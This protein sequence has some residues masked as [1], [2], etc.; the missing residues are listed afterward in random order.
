[1]A[2]HF[3]FWLRHAALH[4]LL[5]IVFFFCGNCKW[6]LVL[7][8]NCELTFLFLRLLVVCS[9]KVFYIYSRDHLRVRFSS[10]FI[11]LIDFYF[12][13]KYPQRGVCIRRLI[14]LKK[15]NFNHQKLETTMPKQFSEIFL[16]QNIFVIPF[17]LVNNINEFI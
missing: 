5:K 12:F 4:N 2:C 14:L 13:T 1:M 15:D 8:F 16:G 11:L 10:S 9:L 3:V 17:I 7:F 6:I